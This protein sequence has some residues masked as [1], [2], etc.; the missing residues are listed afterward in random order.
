MSQ[1]QQQEKQGIGSVNGGSINQY[2]NHTSGHRNKGNTNKCI[3]FKKGINLKA[4]YDTLVSNVFSAGDAGAQDQHEKL[5]TNELIS[6]KKIKDN[7]DVMEVFHA[8]KHVNTK[9]FE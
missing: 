2:N 3:N 6:C 8:L 5:F 4:D 7:K 9:I 1:Q